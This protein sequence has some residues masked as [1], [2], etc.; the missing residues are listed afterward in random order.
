MTRLAPMLALLLVASVA[1]TGAAG[2]PAAASVELA[3]LTSPEV[4]ARVAA[5]TTTILVPIGG[6]EQNGPYM[7][8]GKHDVRARL[9]AERI[10][11]R[12]GD[13][14]VAPV[15]AY[16]PE[17]SISPPTEHMRFAGTISIPAA[18]FEATLTGAAESFRAHGFRDV[19]F[20]T[21]HGGY[22]K[23]VQ[24]AVATLDRKW[25]GSGARAHAL[26]EYYRAST[27]GFEAILARH[28]IGAAEAGTH[29]G[30]ADTALMLALDPSLVHADALKSAPPLSPKQGVYGDP[31]RATAALGQLGVDL[32]VDDSVRAIQRVRP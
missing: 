3:D 21:D 24:R 6:T 13:A 5:G 8:L 29:A 14:L 11:T 23:S 25:A 26:P 19:V 9:L 27:A 18:A 17:G 16:V 1:A 32:I 20:L 4:A 28:G 22:I 30:L 31:R 15:I 10:A 7:A 2:A 12:L